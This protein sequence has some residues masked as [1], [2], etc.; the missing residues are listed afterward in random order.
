I[1]PEQALADARPGQDRHREHQRQQEP[2]A[3]LARHRVHRMA[4]MPALAVPRR[5]V[6]PRDRRR[7]VA[8][9]GLAWLT[10]RLAQPAGRVA[11]L[12]AAWPSA[13]VAAATVTRG[14]LG[15]PARRGRRARWPR[16]DRLASIF[17]L[18]VSDATG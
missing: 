3:H 4:R 6:R 12:A 11:A 14:M 5:V 15:E 9:L 8:V 1:V 2:V 7:V 18:S 17:Y 13:V 10:P 16:P